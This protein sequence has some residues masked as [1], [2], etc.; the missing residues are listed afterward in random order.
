VHDPLNRGGYDD[1][2]LRWHFPDPSP[3][4]RPQHPAKRTKRPG[5]PPVAG[6]SAPAQ[7]HWASPF[8]PSERLN[9]LAQSRFFDFD[10]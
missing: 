5:N 4:T 3:I 10:E 2:T 1:I 8:G 6:L 9:R 7:R